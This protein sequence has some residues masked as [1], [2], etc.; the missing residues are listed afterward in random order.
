MGKFSDAEMVL[1]LLEAAFSI[2][3]FIFELM[4]GSA[5]STRLGNCL[6][7]A[8]IGSDINAAKSINRSS[9]VVDSVK[10]APFPLEVV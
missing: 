4:L 9:T 1:K 8:G 7:A 6:R 5:G 2:H 3:Q 10:T